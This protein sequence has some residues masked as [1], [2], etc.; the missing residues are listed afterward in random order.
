MSP[1]QSW[2]GIRAKAL[3]AVLLDL[4]LTITDDEA[5][6]ILDENV[7]EYA[8]TTGANRRT[9]ERDYT[10]EHLVAFAQSLALSISDEAPGADLVDFERT[11]SM[12]V[13]AVGL[14]TAA[15]A[16]SLK[17]A[18]INLDDKASAAGLSLLSTLGMITAEATTSVVPVPRPLLLRIARFLDI[19]ARSVSNGATLPDGLEQLSREDFA[20]I[21]HQDATGVRTIANADADD[22]SELWRAPNPR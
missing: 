8:A 16:E 3:R 20:D 11:I 18:H 10:D 5:R 1:Q 19:A 21:L 12:P 2:L 15:V 13:A 4:G 22:I 7:N 14:T 6:S 17:V 9:A